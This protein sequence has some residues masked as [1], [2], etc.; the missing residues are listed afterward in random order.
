M[1]L[2]LLAHYVFSE[3]VTK[4]CENNLVKEKPKFQKIRKNA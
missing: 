1:P 4:I 3:N 2:L